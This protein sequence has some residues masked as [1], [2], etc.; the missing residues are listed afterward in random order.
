MCCVAL[1]FAGDPW[2]LCLIVP[3]VAG[4]VW[5]CFVFGIVCF[6]WTAVFCY[7][8]VVSMVWF[9]CEYCVLLICC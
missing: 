5:V 1:G 9:V 6:R 4:W 2:V 3:M 8:V 7:C